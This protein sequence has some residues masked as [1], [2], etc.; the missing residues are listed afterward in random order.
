M[1]VSSWMRIEIGLWLLNLSF[2]FDFQKAIWTLMSKKSNGFVFGE[3]IG[4]TCT[5]Q[6]N[7]FGFVPLTR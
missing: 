4:E 1:S 6:T 2:G 3:N 5:G 7:K